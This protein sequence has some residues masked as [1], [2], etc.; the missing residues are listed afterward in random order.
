MCT[1]SLGGFG[2]VVNMR[3][4]ESRRGGVRFVWL[5]DICPL[6]PGAADVEPNELFSSGDTLGATFA[7]TRLPS[8]SW[9]QSP[10]EL[11]AGRRI[12]PGHAH[13]L[14][15]RGEEFEIPLEHAERQVL[16]LLARPLGD[17]APDVRRGARGELESTAARRHGQSELAVE[18]LRLAEIRDDEMEPIQRMDAEFAGSAAR[19]DEAPY[20]RHD[21]LPFHL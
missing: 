14:K 16:V 15:A 7:S 12:E 13:R 18:I 5:R 10:F 6:T 8:W 4:C 20:C 11:L 19:F 3:M 9:N 2:P 1:K 17:R 21:F